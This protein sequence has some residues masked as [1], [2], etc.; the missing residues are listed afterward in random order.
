MHK[1]VCSRLELSFYFFYFICNLTDGAI[2][3]TDTARIQHLQPKDKLKFKKRGRKF[4][5]KTE[6]KQLEDT[7]LIK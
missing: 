7:D 5:I 3:K 1:K 4:P 2:I 6:E